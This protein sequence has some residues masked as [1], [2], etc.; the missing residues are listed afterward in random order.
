VATANYLNKE[1]IRMRQ[2]QS[3]KNA[4]ES[5]NLNSFEMPQ[6]RQQIKSE[7]IVCQNL[8]LATPSGRIIV[9]DLALSVLPG[10]KLAIIG[11]EGTGKSS[12]LR[13]MGNLMDDSFSSTGQVAHGKLGYVAQLLSDEWRERTVA[14]YLLASAPSLEVE[15]ERWNDAV[16]AIRA[17]TQVGLDH[18][19]FDSARPLR[20]YSGGEL[21]KLSIARAI[22]DD[23]D[24]LLLDEPSN[25]L[26]LET[27]QWL[28]G[29]LLD[30]DK[31][32]A[33]VSHD[34][35]LISAVATKV[36]YLQHIPHLDET[37][38]TI[39]HEDYNTFKQRIENDRAR[40]EG[41]IE[42]EKKYEKQ[43]KK[44]ISEMVSKA[45]SRERKNR[46]T[47]MATKNRANSG[48]AK[49]KAEIAK[50]RER[51]ENRPVLDREFRED[52][53]KLLFP[54]SSSIAAGANVADF[55]GLRIEHEGRVLC[56]S[57]DLSINGPER[58]AIVGRNGAGKSSF[59]KAILPLLSERPSLRVG[60]MP[61]DY[62]ELFNSPDMKVLDFIASYNS[63]LTFCRTVLGRLQLGNQ[64]VIGAVKDLSGGQRA[65]VLIAA[66]MLGGANVLLLDEPTTNL[67]PL[68]SPAL[69]EAL[70]AFPGAIIVV[71]HDRN[72]VTAVADRVLEFTKEGL[73]EGAGL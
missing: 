14:E 60:Y 49:A 32:V 10:E 40:S 53:I 52:Q 29:F 55:R 18:D 27:L 13:A 67:S 64:E 19:L 46:G 69:A 21:V 20:T 45:D 54:A 12:L 38:V 42:K 23:P 57:I 59:L 28:E 24:G 3:Q 11:M 66:L 61:Q 58:I 31:P 6:G 68:S 5:L 71:S 25:F 65:K 30:Y 62:S 2:E 9:Q 70:R 15:A 50:L 35:A 8:T 73:L 34:E 16:L 47:D 51:L 43:V 4:D 33:F 7:G 1:Q 22:A 72:F 36:L 56:E 39:S 44:Q 37:R 48:A 41:V 17:L 63:D 26:D